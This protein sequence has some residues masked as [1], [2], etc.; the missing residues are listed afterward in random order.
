MRSTITAIQMGVRVVGV[1]QLVL[2]LV[3]WTGNALGLVDLHQL[4]GILLVLALWTLAGMAARAGVPAG[5][6]AGAVVLGLVVP[7]VGLTQRELLAG[8]AHW[9]VQVLHLLLGLGLLGL[10]ENLAARAKARLAPVA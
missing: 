5:M 8:S 4:L 3:F 10:A 2:G 7:V 6:V 9:L 1:V